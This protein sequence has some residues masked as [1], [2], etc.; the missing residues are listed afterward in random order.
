[1]ATVAVAA[2]FASASQ[3][4]G[5]PGAAT[6]MSYTEDSP[7][8]PAWSTVG[9]VTEQSTQTNTAI[10]GASI[11]GATAGIGVTTTSGTQTGD[12]NSVTANA[13]KAS[14]SGNVFGQTLDLATINA[15]AG[16]PEHTGAAVLSYASNA[17]GATVSS[18]VTGDSFT[19][20]LD[21]FASGS[22]VNN[23]NTISATTT[24]N[25][26]TTS[27]AGTIPNGYTS[28][29]PGSSTLTYPVDLVT[30]QIFK[31]AGTVVA[32][33]AQQT[34][35]S[36]A[37]ATASSNAAALQLAS[38][39]DN[40]IT[41]GPELENNT[42]AATLKNNSARTNIDIQA[43]DAPTFAG[44]AVVTNLQSNTTSGALGASATN[45][46]SQIIAQIAGNATVGAVD[47]LSGGLTVSG[48]AISSAA[49]G[50]ESLGA[51]AGSSGNSIQLA[52][53]LAF[54][55]AGGPAG[56]TIA[57]NNGAVS[58]T[59]TG[60]LAIQNSQGNTGAS[61]SH[62]TLASSTTNGQVA[63][64]V[65][66]L[67][68]GS[69]TLSGNSVTAA[70][71]G[72]A[73]SSSLS[74]GT[75]SAQFQGTVALANQQTN[76]NTDLS[77][78]NG[79][80]SVSALTGADTDVGVTH[81][82][83]VAVSNNS[84]GATG[85]GNS[86][87]QSVTLDASNVNI[88]A[89]QAFLTGGTFLDGNVSAA[90]GATVASLQSAYA[91]Q[92]DVT[93][94]GSSIGL[95]AD[96]RGLGDQTIIQASSLSTA[97]NTQE[98]VA[99]VNASS[100]SL[101]LTSAADGPGT[102]AGVANVQIQANDAP[103]SATLS[104]AATGVIA[105]THVE[106]SQLASTGNLQRAI[107]YG[108]TTANTLDVSTT[109]LTAAPAVSPG[110]L[111]ALDPSSASALDGAVEPT[112]TAAYGVL[113]DQSSL[114]DVT[115]TTTRSA[116]QS[117]LGVLVEGHVHGSSVTNDG[118]AYVA[119]GYG[120]DAAN[121]ATLALGNVNAVGGGFAP[122]GSLANAQNST[123]D[124]TATASGG[125]VVTTEIDRDVAGS[126]VSTSGNTI[127]ALG[128]ATHASQ[129]A[130]TVDGGVINTTP[131]TGTAGGVS[132][133][134]DITGGTMTANAAFDLQNAQSAQGSVT[135]S[136]L[137]N[138]TTPTTAAGVL[139]TVAGDVANSTLTSASNQSLA[140]A[141]GN[142]ATNTLTLTADNAA[143]STGLQNVQYSNAA[144]SSQIG[145]KGSEGAPG[146]STAASG[147]GSGFL[148]V[149][150]DTL[151]VSN[152]P[153]TVTFS[154]HAFT[155][156]E[157]A[158]LN[159]LPNISGAVLGGNTITLGV[160]N[161]DTS[162]FSGFSFS[163]GA[164]GSNSGDETF[165][166][167]GFSQPAS[168]GSPN[169]GGVTLAVG[170]ASI[171]NS[172]LAVANNVTAGS[173]VGNSAANSLAVTGTNVTPGAGLAGASVP[174]DV[175]GAVADHALSNVQLTDTAPTSN[176]VYGT[177]A[178]SAADS[179]AISGSTLSVSDNS[180]S[181][182]ANANT[183]SNAL[184]VTAANLSAGSALASFQ[185]SASQVSALSDLEVFAPAAVSNASVELSGNSNSALGV[186]NDV[187]NTL[188]VSAAN[189]S[190]VSTP[191]A[192]TLDPSGTNVAA[193]DHVL[194]NQQE[195]DTSVTS[196]AATRI[197]N[198]DKAAAATTGLA[199]SSLTIA[200]NTT[201]AEASAN[202]ALNTA[203]VNGS[204]MQGASVGLE[205]LQMSGAAVLA[206]AT[207]AAGVS[208]A[209]GAGA[210]AAAALNVG[211]V[212][213]DGNSTTAL[214]RGNAATNSLS[215]SAASG[216]GAGY[217]G[218]SSQTAIA[219]DR[220][221]AQSAVLNQ[222]ANSGP[223]SAMSAGATYTVALNSPLAAAGVS[224]GTVGLTGNKVASAAFGNTATNQLT[225]A[226]LNTGAPTAAVGNFQSN[227]GAVTASATSVSFQVTASGGPVTGSSLR[228]SGN[229]ISATAVGNSAVS[230]I[231]AAR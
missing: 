114:G 183:G 211:S 13:M 11:A 63:A 102:G 112:V 140:G 175:A 189:V 220:V 117:G 27:I 96:S 72:N 145:L 142:A 137:D 77:V 60:D 203:S 7:P 50:N 210:P 83:T 225:V 176:A 57:Y 200:G 55:G 34:A 81:N 156:A 23:D 138:P 181:A 52:D 37:T 84:I 186:I 56:S 113:N 21:N 49:T 108:G 45:S 229:Q 100:N 149:A 188:A 193:A 95:D 197:Y 118:N 201:S 59:V 152:A 111:I 67:D 26:G 228:A 153:V 169:Q 97:N 123:G 75:A 5:D 91:S 3:A 1:V 36:T 107:A 191:T 161:I 64:D 43:G 53:G 38:E 165:T 6:S 19:V 215:V 79:G 131:A 82:A 128:F 166:V 12:S 73:A 20:S 88:G 171:T 226:A 28:D 106:N 124:I 148:S 129:N 29:A 179:A 230:A 18:A 76:Y 22:A 185:G 116:A 104:D 160:G 25:D 51:A 214:A 182:T 174:G 221:T 78:L 41:S 46:G 208:L 33:S 24:V 58:S 187:S 195:A 198:Q 196:T 105:S 167:T 122:I 32:T 202:R 115:A 69:I 74:T 87:T 132:Y 224:N 89:G 92:L 61:G 151:V 15:S 103:V 30:G 150:G 47:T 40:T 93:N 110:S 10:V 162:V 126:T 217:D 90:G 16:D 134:G 212:S 4:A 42:I 101:S 178:I 164:D 143:T 157:A 231:T 65:Q 85:K 127:Q 44:S 173:T 119:A 9:H 227:S 147:S 190:P 141:N 139:T 2:L 135:A 205:N 155:A 133:A 62:G 172:T 209:G 130:L 17:P 14:A 99:V 70:T 223:V 163:S 39:S 170:G 177:F 199:N 35:D 219:D 218:G 31:A 121:A 154:G 192:A 184:T 146:F 66:S 68:G 213:L 98:A 180:Q 94:S 80:G 144:L 206:D 48:N 125:D 194:F 8:S 207:T 159:S 109:G 86:V 204:A 158:Y 54:Q 216:Y 168:A 71:T 222:Q 136:Q 120:A